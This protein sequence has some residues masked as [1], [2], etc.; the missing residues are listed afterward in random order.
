MKIQRQLR[1]ALGIS[2]LAVTLLAATP[3]FADRYE[4][5]YAGHPLRIVAYLAHPIGV[6]IDYLVLRPAHWVGEFEP[7]AT[8]FGHEG[9]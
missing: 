6:M 4:A 2:L 9:D 7:F 3:A 5:E 1:R 8:L